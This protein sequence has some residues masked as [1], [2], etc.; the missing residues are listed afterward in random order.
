MIRQRPIDLNPHVSGWPQVVKITYPAHHS[1]SRYWMLEAMKF[2][3][4]DGRAS[5]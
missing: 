5:A 2:V 4:H 1:R 3:P